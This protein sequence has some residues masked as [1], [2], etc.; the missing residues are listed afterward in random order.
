M[1]SSPLARLSYL[2]DPVVVICSANARQRLATVEAELVVAGIG[3]DDVGTLV[4]RRQLLRAFR[5]LLA[6]GHSEEQ[7]N[8]YQREQSHRD[9]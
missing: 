1:V 3:V 2:P 5:K 6:D 8:M 4:G 7:R 9:L